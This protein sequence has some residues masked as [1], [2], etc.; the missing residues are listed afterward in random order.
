MDGSFACEHQ[1]AEVK[2]F[3]VTNAAV[4][5]KLIVLMVVSGA[6]RGRSTPANT[7][8]KY[9]M[10]SFWIKIYINKIAFNHQREK[11]T[12]LQ[13]VQKIPIFWKAI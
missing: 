2:I 6:D 7:D 8:A 12:M 3:Q 10:S 5:W 4:S 9:V 13:V 11:Q 1:C